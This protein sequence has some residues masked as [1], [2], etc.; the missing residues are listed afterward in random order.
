MLVKFGYW[1]IISK[2]WFEISTPDFGQKCKT[3][4]WRKV[5]VRELRPAAILNPKKRYISV[6][7][8]ILHNAIQYENTKLPK[9]LFKIKK[10]E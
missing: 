1:F 2:Y 7:T 9:W 3:H 5:Y 4:F 6:H 10:N 8:E